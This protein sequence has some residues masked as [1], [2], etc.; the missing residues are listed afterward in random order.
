MD[1]EA[2][3]LWPRVVSMVDI[4]RQGYRKASVV[5]EMNSLGQM[6]CRVDGFNVDLL[7]LSGFGPGS[8]A[9][10][11]GCRT[12]RLGGS[13]TARAFDSESKGVVR[14]RSGAAMLFLA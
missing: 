9:P 8:A 7:G 13:E 11:V 4:S 3:R 5:S 12:M 6:L 14:C 10:A 2:R 1:C